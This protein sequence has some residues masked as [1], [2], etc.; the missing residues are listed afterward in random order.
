M[1]VTGILESWSG[2]R[3]RV[4]AKGHEC[5]HVCVQGQ[6][7]P[8]L[9]V[10]HRSLSQHRGSGALGRTGLQLPRKQNFHTRGGE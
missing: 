5:A 6:Q 2:P 3:G 1:A 8:G 4:K 10:N 7:V 9:A